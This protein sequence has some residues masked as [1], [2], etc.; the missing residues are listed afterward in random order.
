MTLTESKLEEAR[1]FLRHL[2][3]RPKFPEFDYY[4]NAFISSARSVTWVMKAE[5]ADVAG[6][7]EWYDSKA[8]TAEIEPILGAI[9]DARNRSQKRGTVSAQARATIEIPPSNPNIAAV[10]LTD[11]PGKVEIVPIDGTEANRA[12]L[13][14]RRV[15]ALCTVKGVFSEIEELAGQDI[16]TACG[17]YVQWLD[18][19]VDECRKSFEHI[20][21]GTQSRPA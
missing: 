20:A 17:K 21:H 5:Y 7:N 8:P 13:K 1:F 14:E 16:V 6:W 18:S 2:E 10:L 15:I 4:L 9:T 11:A 3:A 12:M 19:V